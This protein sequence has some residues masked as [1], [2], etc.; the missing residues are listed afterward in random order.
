MEFYFPELEWM[1]AVP[2]GELRHPVVAK[3]LKAEGVKAGVLDVFLLEPRG[4]YPGFVMENKTPDGPVSDEQKRWIAYFKQRGFK[5]V[6]CRNVDESK[7][8]LIDYLNLPPPL[9]VDLTPIP[10][11]DPNPYRKRKRKCKKSTVK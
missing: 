3:R 6:V 11:L 10:K 5:V 2:N 4:E 9:F 8:A 1:F 7:K